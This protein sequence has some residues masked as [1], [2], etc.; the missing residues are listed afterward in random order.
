VS[1]K[2]QQCRWMATRNSKWMTPFVCS[3]KRWVLLA[4]KNEHYVEIG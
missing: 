1:V 3:K 4:L 2:Q